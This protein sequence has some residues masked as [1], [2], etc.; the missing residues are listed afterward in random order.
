MYC[1][2]VS[3]HLRSVH[4]VAHKFYGNVKKTTTCKYLTLMT[5][6][7]KWGKYTDNCN[8]Q[9]KHKSW[10]VDEYSNGEMKGYMVT[11]V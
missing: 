5:Y 2:K 9:R 3:I 10:L 6:K 1:Q 4:F 11:Q 8:L 7:V